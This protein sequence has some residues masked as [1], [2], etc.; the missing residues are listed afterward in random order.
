MLPQLCISKPVHIRF[1]NF[2][3]YFFQILL[4]WQNLGLVIF[5]SLERIRIVSFLAEKPNIS[6]C[7]NIAIIVRS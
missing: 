1:A 4:K 5:A 6:R 3:N 2:T 7:L